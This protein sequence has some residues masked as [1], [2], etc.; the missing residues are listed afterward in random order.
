MKYNRETDKKRD[1]KKNQDLPQWESK[2]QKCYFRTRI[3]AHSPLLILKSLIS[4]EKN[5]N[6]TIPFVSDKIKQI[7]AHRKAVK[8]DMRSWK[9]GNHIIS[10]YVLQFEQY[11]PSQMNKTKRR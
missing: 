10:I 7:S 6:G 5:L 11:S 9:L 1:S 8:M 2:Q 3:E 4:Q